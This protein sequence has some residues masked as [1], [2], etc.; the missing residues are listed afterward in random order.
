MSKQVTHNTGIADIAPLC[1]I[2][3]VNIFFGGE[4][5]ADIANGINWA[6]NQGQ[7][8]VLSN[9][10]G[11]TTYSQTQPGFDVIIQAINNAR[12][13]GRSGLGSIVVF[14]AG[15]NFG[16][17]VNDVAFPANV[18]GVITVGA[19][20]NAAP[21]GNIWYY[22][23]RGPSMDLVAPSGD[24]NLTG[25]LTTL[26]RMGN[27]GYE[28]GNYTGRFGGTS[29]AC[30]QVSGIAALMVS[31]NP[32]LTEAQVKTIL[33]TTATDMGTTGFDNTF[34]YGRL[35]CPKIG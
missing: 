16:N 4:T 3:P 25:D 7:A 19:C 13:Q 15:N 26:D 23:E 6:W 20:N 32:I 12:T 21:A 22:S 8:S 10:W 2:V 34:G 9:S 30:P 31:V 11:F 17:G 27:L 28:V 35:S 24:L 5:T 29:A 1:N 33:Q 14:A 18:N